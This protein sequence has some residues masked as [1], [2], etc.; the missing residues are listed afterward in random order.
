M[1]PS[2]FQI[3]QILLVG[4][5]NLCEAAQKS[6]KI[7]FRAKINKILASL[8]NNPIFLQPVTRVGLY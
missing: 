1:Y 4:L 6:L 2:S 5:A 8:R 3:L 7:K